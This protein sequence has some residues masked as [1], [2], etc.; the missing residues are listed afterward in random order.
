MRYFKWGVARL[1]LEPERHPAVV[2]IFFTGMEEI[3]DEDRRFPRLLPR[4]WKKVQLRFGE[5]VES[6]WTDLRKEWAALRKGHSDMPMSQLAETPEGR[7]L[8]VSATARARNLVVGLRRQMSLPEENAN[9]ALVE[10]Y[11]TPDRQREGRQTG[12]ASEKDSLI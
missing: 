12:G 2:P 11:K 1:L 4:L 10:T 5:C 8:R 6:G 3:M 7:N 9:A